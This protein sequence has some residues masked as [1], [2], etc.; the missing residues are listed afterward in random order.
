MNRAGKGPFLEV[1]EL[2]EDPLEH[3][4]W[5]SLDFASGFGCLDL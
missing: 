3:F 2:N 4:F 5:G 1:A